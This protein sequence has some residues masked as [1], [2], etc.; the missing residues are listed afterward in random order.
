MTAKEL[1]NLSGLLKEEPA[2]KRAVTEFKQLHPAGQI[3]SSMEEQLHTTQKEIR[4]LSAWIDAIPDADMRA[5][6]IC[7][8]FLG[9]EWTRVARECGYGSADSARVAFHRFIKKENE[10]RGK[11]GH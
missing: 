8:C 6:A 4:R 3:V 9:M 1:S 7:R 11:N 2:L 10:R 5:V